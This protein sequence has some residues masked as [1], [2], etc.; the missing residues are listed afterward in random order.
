ML[1]ECMTLRA[2]NLVINALALHKPPIE[3]FFLENYLGAKGVLDPDWAESL[4]ED[5]DWRVITCDSQKPRGEKAKLKGPPL[6]L[7]LPAKKITGF[8]LG[9]SIPNRPGF[10]KFRAVV[11][12]WPQVLKVATDASPG[13]RFKITAH[14]DNYR[15]EEWPL[16][17]PSSR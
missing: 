2:S 5:G 10:E 15:I 9:G 16:P 6:H 14:G 4:A 1:D 17:L 8:F 13:T 12:V 11:C 7:I 3:A